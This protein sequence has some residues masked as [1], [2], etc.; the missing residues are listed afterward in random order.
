MHSPPNSG[1]TYN[2]EP[3][4]SD[5]MKITQT[6]HGSVNGMLRPAAIKLLKGNFKLNVSPKTLSARHFEYNLINLGSNNLS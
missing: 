1:N 4:R 6:T 5:V 3:K 2:P